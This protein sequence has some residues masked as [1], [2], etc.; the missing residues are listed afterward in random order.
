MRTFIEIPS[1][2][3]IRA[4]LVSEDN[5][6][7][8]GWASHEVMHPALQHHTRRG[9]RNPRGWNMAC[10][11]AISPMLVDAGLTLPKDVLLD[12]RFWGMSAE[13]IY[14]LLEGKE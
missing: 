8:L 13:R 11:Y 14:N 4:D 2:M 7:L 10:D 1:E 9:G 3:G 6:S 12:N 5:R